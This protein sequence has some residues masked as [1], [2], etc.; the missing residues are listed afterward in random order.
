MEN[1]SEEQKAII[2]EQR[3][4]ASEQSAAIFSTLDTNGDGRLT[5]SELIAAATNTPGALPNE[6]TQEEV[7]QFLQ[8]YD[9]NSD[10]VV[11]L[12]E[13]KSFHL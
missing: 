3:Q 5:R 4:R 6:A 11:T 10:G 12:D 13:W 1:L 2:T 8:T 7:A 9:Q